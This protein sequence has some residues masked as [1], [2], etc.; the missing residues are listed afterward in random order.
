MD[1]TAHVGV[2]E[3]CLRLRMRRWRRLSARGM[4]LLAPWQA[5]PR[6]LRDLRA[7]TAQPANKHKQAIKQAQMEMTIGIDMKE[8]LGL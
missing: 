3:T 1:A 4:G 7:E 5:P 8:I 2:D 6:S